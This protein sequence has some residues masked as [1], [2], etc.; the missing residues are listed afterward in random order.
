MSYLP[1][2]NE[3]TSLLQYNRWDW[4]GGV[5]YTGIT[6]TAFG[7]Y[8]FV[9]RHLMTEPGTEVWLLPILFISEK[10]LRILG[11]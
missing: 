1:S 4:M 11:C 9:G 7:G 10:S 5:A 3:I 2:S 6:A 8:K